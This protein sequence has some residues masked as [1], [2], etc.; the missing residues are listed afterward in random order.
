MKIVRTIVWILTVL[1]ALALFWFAATISMF[2]I[3]DM[4]R[5]RFSVEQQ[6]EIC[7]V[8][9][10]E[11]APGETLATRFNPGFGP[12]RINLTVTVR[13]VVSEEDFMKRLKAEWVPAPEEWGGENLDLFPPEEYD[14]WE[15][16]STIYF[17]NGT[18]TFFVRGYFTPLKNIYTFLYNPWQPI[19]TNPF[20]AGGIALELAFILFLILTRR[21]KEKSY[22]R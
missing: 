8:F 16:S 18:A 7:R 2:N 22:A 11:L 10:F 14:S 6:D 5:T 12:H 1:L 20:I 3:G 17:E 4:T 15:D 9:K 21:K 13:G 19:F